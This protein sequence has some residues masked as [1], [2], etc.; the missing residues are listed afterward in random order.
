MHPKVESALALIRDPAS[1]F[2]VNEIAS[3][4]GCSAQR[5]CRL[6][7]LGTGTTPGKYIKTRKLRAAAKLLRH[8]PCTVREAARVTGHA[9]LS[10]FV[11]E[12][13]RYFGVRP[14]ELKSQK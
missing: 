12:F 10:H 13:K 8:S 2:N 1:S 5:L 3:L 14:G 9:D 11:R 6:F 4:I 7:R